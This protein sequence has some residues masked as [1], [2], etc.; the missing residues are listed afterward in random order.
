[1]DSDLSARQIVEKSM[2]IAGEIC[3][4]TNDN[5]TYEELSISS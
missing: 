2:K 4:Y 3:L 5:V 1:M